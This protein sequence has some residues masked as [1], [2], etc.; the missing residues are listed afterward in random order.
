MITLDTFAESNV[1]IIPQGD[2]EDSNSLILD[3]VR[4]VATYT[5]NEK[6]YAIATSANEDGVQIIDITDPAN[7]ITKGMLI[8]DSSNTLFGSLSI[9][10]YSIG[11]EYFAIVGAN[12]DKALQTLHITNPDG[13]SSRASVDFTHT[14]ATSLANLFDIATYTI[15]NNHY[16]VSTATK[17]IQVFEITNN[18]IIS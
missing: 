1:V 11:G 2:V 18:T 8:D 7:P 16:A 3:N 9:A 15:G 14:Q 13:I 17:K 4:R 12:G 6:H 10:T 5:I